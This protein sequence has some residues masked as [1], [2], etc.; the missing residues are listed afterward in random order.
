MSE[1]FLIDHEVGSRL[2]V[3]PVRVHPVY[4]NETPK[5]KD[6]LEPE[7]KKVVS[8][9]KDSGPPGT[10]SVLLVTTVLVTIHRSR[11]GTDTG[12]SEVENY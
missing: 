3:S 1:P 8:E 10:A 2:T 6:P 12:L 7:G 11:L 4:S 5:R 9:S